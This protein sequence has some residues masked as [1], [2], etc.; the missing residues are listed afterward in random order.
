MLE[1][2]P[3]GKIMGFRFVVLMLCQVNAPPSAEGAKEKVGRVGSGLVGS[4]FQRAGQLGCSPATNSFSQCLP[5]SY[6]IVVKQL[7]S[8]TSAKVSSRY[9][10]LD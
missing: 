1:F 6:Q 5:L 8:L 2:F 7:T 9:L 4:S 10:V 3:I